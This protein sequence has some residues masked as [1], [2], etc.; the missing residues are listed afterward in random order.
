VLV[1]L[2]LGTEGIQYLHDLVLLQR[3]SQHLQEVAPAAYNC[4]DSGQLADGNLQ[5]SQVTVQ[6]FVRSRF[7][8]NMPSML[9][10]RLVLTEVRLSWQNIP[11]DPKHWMGD[12]QPRQLPV[13]SLSAVLTDHHDK[14][15][16]LQHGIELLLD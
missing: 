2:P 5:I 8:Q 15:I 14:A 7:D 1:V 9:K 11:Y 3:A 12:R 16:N 13:V 10:N 4:L 6:N